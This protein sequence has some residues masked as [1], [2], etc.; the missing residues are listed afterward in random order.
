MHKNEKNRPKMAPKGYLLRFI[1]IVISFSWK[2]SKMKNYIIW[3]SH[4][5]AMGQNALMQLD[6]RTP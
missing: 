4:S 1:K 6:C 2:Y 3:N 5:Q